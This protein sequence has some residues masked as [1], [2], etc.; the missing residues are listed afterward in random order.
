[1]DPHVRSLLDMGSVAVP[2]ERVMMDVR[3][4]LLEEHPT[5]QVRDLERWLY[6]SPERGRATVRLVENPILPGQL[7]GEA[8]A[9]EI[10]SVATEAVVPLLTAVGGWLI[11]RA[12]RKIRV[13]IELNGKKVE[14]ESAGIKEPLDL[15]E[16]LR[17]LLDEEP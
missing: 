5:A 14:I 7:G 6:R 11:A 9:V 1:M 2:L 13:S 17:D 16:R 15:V 4:E 3:I 12:N 10:L 8:A